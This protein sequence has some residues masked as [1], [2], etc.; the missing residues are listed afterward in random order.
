MKKVILLTIT[1]ML[2]LLTSEMNQ[3][4]AQTQFATVRLYADGNNST[5]YI[6]KGSS[7][8]VAMDLS[9]ELFEVKKYSEQIN[10]DNKIINAQFEALYN[11]GFRLISTA[12]SEPSFGQFPSK[13][14]EIIY[15]L[16]KE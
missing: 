1:A 14:L 4:F 10:A 6:S 9:Q 15:L 11:E 12:L 3:L 5:L 2:L 8:A 16:A 13:Y 7:D